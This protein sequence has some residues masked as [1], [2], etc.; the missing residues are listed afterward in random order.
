[1]AC[2]PITGA[3]RRLASGSP[4]GRKHRHGSADGHVL[5]RTNRQPPAALVAAA[6]LPAPPPSLVQLPPTAL[7]G[8][9]LFPA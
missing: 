7:P 6:D 2:S 1:V 4:V 3:S 9:Q 8:L 5:R